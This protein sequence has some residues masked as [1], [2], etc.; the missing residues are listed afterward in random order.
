[1]MP[2][3]LLGGRRVSFL[4][5]FHSPWRM[6]IHAFHSLEQVVTKRVV[7]LET[8]LDRVIVDRSI[9]DLA[10][11]LLHDVQGGNPSGGSLQ[12]A[13]GLADIF[14]VPC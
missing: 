7:R 3:S 1:M 12:S 10:K 9:L 8:S 14:V 5:T 6:I 2:L 13:S 11:L 4:W